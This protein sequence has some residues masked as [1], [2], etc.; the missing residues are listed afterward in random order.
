MAKKGGG[1]YAQN[2]EAIT[3]GLNIAFSHPLLF[4]M[5]EFELATN[6]TALELGQNEWLRAECYACDGSTCSWTGRVSETPVTI[7]PNIRR[8]APAEQ[9]AYIFTRVQIHIVMN[10]LDPQRPELSW[11]QA[12]WFFAEHMVLGAGIGAR[13]PEFSPLPTGLLRGDEEALAEFLGR[14]SNGSDLANRPDLESLSL[15]LPGKPFWSFA[16]TFNIPKEL[17][18][19]RAGDFARGVRKAASAAI[20]VAGG[21]R[22][23]LGGRKQVDSFAKRACDWMISEYPLLAALA[24]S[25]KL[26]EDEEICRNMAVEVAAICDET[27]EIYINPRISLNEEEARFVLAHEFLHA[28]LRHMARRQGRDAGYWNI[29]CDFI[30]NDWLIEMKLGTPPERLGYLYDPA[31]KGLSVEEVYDQ[32]VRDVRWMRKL[33]KAR[34]MNGGGADMMEGAHKPAWWRGG[35]CDLDAFYRRALSE[36]LELH[37]G[38]GRGFLPAGLVEEIRSLMQP[39][40]PWDVELAQWLDQ[41]F[42]PIEK[43]RSYARAHRRQSATP[44]IPRPAW[45]SPDEQKAARV[46]G[47]VVDTSGSMSRADLGKAVGAIAS[48]AMSRDVGFVRMIQCDAAAHDA[49]FVE[50]EALLDRV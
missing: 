8:R 19:Q 45:V 15:G 18:D 34:T 12:C 44:D 40:I 17:R 21:I 50:P 9:W 3:A 10:H 14:Y 36:G 22:R 49:G 11:H 32:I 31:L 29:A 46:F 43:R 33:K 39:P 30:V 38:R 2:I 27:Q 1:K 25:F 37:L 24:S 26:I 47:A 23:E 6:K 41:F 16:E 42:P 48:Y 13:P 7:W 4:D 20:D 28:G 35:G 5:R